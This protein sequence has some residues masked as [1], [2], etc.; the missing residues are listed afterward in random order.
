MGK[1]IVLLV[2]FVTAG[3]VG[4]FYYRH[5]QDEVRM[6]S[7]DVTCDGCMTPEQHAKFLRDNATENS[8]SQT[9][10]RAKTPVTDDVRTVSAASDSSSTAAPKPVA[11]VQSQMAPVTVA[12]PAASTVAPS[13]SNVTASDAPKSDTILPNPTNGQVFAG[14]GSY[15]WYRQGNLT[16]RVDTTSGRSCIIYA[17][18]E[19][20]RKQ[21]V[22]SHGCGHAA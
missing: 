20:W 15:Q 22:L 19:E 9:E 6:A 1:R 2:I 16:W 21:I 4:Y 14:K 18:M 10:R 8:D 5:H 3:L 12:T 11:P 13:G 17:T 7:G